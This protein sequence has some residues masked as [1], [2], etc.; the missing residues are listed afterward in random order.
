MTGEAPN[1]N[2]WVGL[3]CAGNCSN[4]TPR[5]KTWRLN[6]LAPKLGNACGGSGHD[7]T[8]RMSGTKRQKLSKS[9]WRKKPS[10]DEVE[11]QVDSICMHR[12]SKMPLVYLFTVATLHIFAGNSVIRKRTCPFGWNAYWRGIAVFLNTIWKK[13]CCYY[14]KHWSCGHRHDRNNESHLLGELSINEKWGFV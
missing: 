5:P 8:W 14:G 12:T 11:N 10:S 13:K 4:V 1:T 6:A 2:D 7:R 3:L 9:D